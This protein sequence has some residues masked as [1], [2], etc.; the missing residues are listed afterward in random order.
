VEEEGEHDDGRVRKGRK[1]S[2]R[3]IATSGDG[4]S[5]S[6]KGSFTPNKNVV[7]H[8]DTC[9]NRITPFPL[10]A[11]MIKS[12]L[13]DST[14]R[15]PSIEMSFIQAP[16]SEAL[17]SEIGRVSKGKPHSAQSRGQIKV[18]KQWGHG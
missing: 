3:T 7:P 2:F 11:V 17:F 9:N 13:L 10:V 12:R 6:F 1:K 18:G 15:A 16:L 5:W 8:Q 4:L 14:V